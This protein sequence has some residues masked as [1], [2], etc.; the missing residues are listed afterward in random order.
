MKICKGKLGFSQFIS[1]DSEVG[2]GK[3]ASSLRLDAGGFSDLFML[4]SLRIEKQ[5][6]GQQYVLGEEEMGLMGTWERD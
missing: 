4:L 1:P 5:E 3:G 2:L 6:M